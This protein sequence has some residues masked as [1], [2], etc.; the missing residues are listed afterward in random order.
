MIAELSDDERQ[1]VLEALPEWTYHPARRAIHRRVRFATFG[2]A[3]GAIVRIGVEAEKADH[4]PEWSNCHALLNIW[5]TTHDAGGL[6]RRDV[7]LA[8]AIDR[9]VA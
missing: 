8:R 3:L 6:S 2:D 7:D 5:L 9:I 4:H 1:A